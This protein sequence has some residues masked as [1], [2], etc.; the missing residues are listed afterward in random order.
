MEKIN[1]K[2]DCEGAATGYRCYGEA[3]F[4]HAIS[5]VIRMEIDD[6][7]RR[8]IHISEEEAAVLK[9]VVNREARAAERWE[10]IKVHV[11][12]VGIVA[13]FGWIGK[14]FIDAI[15]ALANRGQP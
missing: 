5:K 11:F 2:E 4:E 15:I 13:I 3:G 6:V 9:A 8:Y 14:I 12:G 1:C 10:K 7:M